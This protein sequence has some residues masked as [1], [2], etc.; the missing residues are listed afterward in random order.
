MDSIKNQ[1]G[2]TFVEIIV[3]M[4][5]F[6]TIASVVLF[7]FRDFSSGISLQNLSQQIALQVSSAQKKALAG[8]RPILQ[9]FIPS[10]SGGTAWLPAYG[11]CF[12]TE[13]NGCTLAS[14]YGA[15][16]QIKGF[17]LFVDDKNDLEYNNPQEKLDT[18][19]IK[20]GD[21]IYELCV[22]EATNPQSSS[23]NVNE[24]QI[25]YTRPD[26]SP[27]IMYDTSLQSA[28]DATVKIQS[29][30]GQTREVVIWKSGQ[31]EVN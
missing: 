8:S 1:K 10:G 30:N 14:Q 4:G 3:V 22:N 25:I 5:I 18:I 29:E 6:A 2:F 12:T 24:L 9:N 15:Q 28:N 31:I 23:C 20:G 7:N 13:A 16:N 26:I 19:E 17:T 27:E 21:Y 11:V